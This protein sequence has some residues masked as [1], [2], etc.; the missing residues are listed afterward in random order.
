MPMNWINRC[1]S[2][3][4]TPA[5]LAGSIAS[6]ALSAHD[7]PAAAPTRFSEH[8]IKSGYSYSYGLAA[9]DLDGD[10]D[11]DITS[12][13]TRIFKLYWFDNDGKG[14]FKEHLIEKEYR[15][16]LER[17]AIGDVDRDGKPDVV[18]IENLHGDVLWYRN[19]GAPAK[20]PGWQRFTITHHTIPGAY[21]V[22]LA[23]LD[24]DADLDVAA[25]TWR[26]SNKF[27]WCENPGD[28]LR[29]EHWKLHIIEENVGET[30]TIR[31][32][33]FNRDGRPD[34]LGTARDTNLTVWYENPGDPRSKPWTRHVIDAKSPQ[35]TH[36]MPADIDRD[37]D[38]DVVMALGMIA[39]AGQTGTREIVWYE[40]AGP[41]KGGEWT[42]HVIGGDFDN[43]FEA[44]AVDI[45]GDGDLDVPATSWGT[46]N[47]RVVWFE[48]SGDPK[49]RWT[50]HE[51]KSN[52]PRANQ[53]IAADL[54]GDKR[55]DLVAGAEVGAN[56]VR[57][58]RNEGRK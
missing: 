52:W 20:E 41:G 55:P 8:L 4:A 31:V 21:D 54:D 22:D 12:A 49:A 48:N 26:L 16:R 42:K 39:A 35:P 25:S 46:P 58:W 1:R 53:I 10:G 32:A 2:L 17:H 38:L 13:D 19:S 5:L 15:D 7:G 30:R 29:G 11:L 57:W 6:I 51:L 27:V 36:G 37:G 47:G 33:D 9:A 40:N 18:I 50:M 24:G 45:D 56:E 23:D 34:L 14:G 43:A 28:V 44:I 3:L